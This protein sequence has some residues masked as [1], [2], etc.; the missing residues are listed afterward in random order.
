MRVSWPAD[1][2]NGRR[3]FPPGVT[4]L[5]SLPGVAPAVTQGDEE[6]ITILAGQIGQSIENVQ[7]FEK[8]FRSS[9]ELELKVADRTKQL[10]ADV[11][12]TYLAHPYTAI[13]VGYTHGLQNID[14][15]LISSL[16]VVARTRDAFL[17]DRRQL[18]MKVSYLLKP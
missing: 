2:P 1:L 9:Q 13:Y 16:N 11:L 18:F 7:L 10:T 8:V 12:L 14:P 6:L 17:N 4:A 15:A 5:S 3:K